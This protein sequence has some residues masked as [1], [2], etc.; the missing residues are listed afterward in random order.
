MVQL[1]LG[2]ATKVGSLQRFVP[3]EGDCEER[4]PGSFPASEVHK[5]AALDLRL[6]NTD[7]NGGNILARRGAGGEWELVPIDHGAERGAARGCAARG[8]SWWWLGGGSVL[9]LPRRACGNRTAPPRAPSRPK[10]RPLAAQA[11]ACPTRS[12][13]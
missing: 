7:R 6:G 2:G 3:S 5:I 4:G 13:I 10:P 11:A 1:E 9:L 12:R 8:R